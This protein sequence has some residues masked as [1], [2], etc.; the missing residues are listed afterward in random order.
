MIFQTRLV[1]NIGPFGGNVKGTVSIVRHGNYLWLYNGDS[2]GIPLKHP[3][4]QERSV[5]KAYSPDSAPFFTN[6]LSDT[7]YPR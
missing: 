4:R 2:I 3:V 6:G 5:L 7:T 1:E